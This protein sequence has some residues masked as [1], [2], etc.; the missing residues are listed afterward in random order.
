MCGSFCYRL[1]SGTTAQ[2]TAENFKGTDRQMGAYDHYKT[3]VLEASLWLSE[4]GYFGSLRGTGGNVSMRVAGTDLIAITPSSMKYQEITVDDICIVRPDG[5]LLEGTHAPSMETGMH[6]AVYGKRPDTNAL[7]HTHQ[8]YGSVFAL[9]NLPIPL[10]LDEVAL[11]LGE[12][13]EVAP[14]AFSGT[15]ELAL[16]VAN[17]LKNNA[18]ACII[19]NHGVITL[20]ET[21]DKALLAAELLEKTARIYCLALSTGNPVTTLPKEIREKVRRMREAESG[22]AQPK[23]PT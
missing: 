16:N 11:T 4:Q 13:I 8:T 22:K 15:A 17:T 10:L 6:L 1:A 7:V 5:A 2:W 12:T 18:N 3:E 20:G 14:Y 21:M 23:P 19:Q 9:L